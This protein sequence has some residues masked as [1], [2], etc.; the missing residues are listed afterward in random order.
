[1]Y[2]STLNCLDGMGYKHGDYKYV[3]LF[4]DYLH[5]KSMG[6]KVVYVV[7]VLADKYAVSERK[8]YDII[9]RFSKD[10]NICAV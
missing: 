7:A 3:P 10:C 5:M 2:G 4:E 6:N 1:M 9:A 8:V